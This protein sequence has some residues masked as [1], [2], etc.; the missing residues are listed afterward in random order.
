MI[1]K[2]A[3]IFSDRELMLCKTKEEATAKVMDAAAEMAK[4]V[5]LGCKLVEKATSPGSSLLSI[6][7]IFMFE[8]EPMK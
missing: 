1:A 2:V 7:Y 4:S 5:G 6:N 3:L 8:C